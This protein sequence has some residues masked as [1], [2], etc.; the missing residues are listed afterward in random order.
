MARRHA[1][2]GGVLASRTTASAT[3]TATGARAGSAAV[4]ARAAPA[5]SAL[6]SRTFVCPR[7]STSRPSSGPP[8]PSEAAKAPATMPAVA[9]EPVRWRTWTSS[10]MLSMAIGRRAM[11]EMEARRRTPGNER[12]EAMPRD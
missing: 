1:S 7:R 6:V 2:T 3:S 12:S 11:I 5:T 10:A 9:N 8:T 4:P